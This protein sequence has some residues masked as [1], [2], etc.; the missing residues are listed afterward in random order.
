MGKE[1]DMTTN[2]AV[3]P[4]DYPTDDMLTRIADAQWGEKNN[5]VVFHDIHRHNACNHTLSGTI[6]EGE[7]EYGF[8]IHSGD[9]GGTVVEEWGLSE[10]VGS[11]RPEWI[12]PAT[13]VPSNSFLI[14]ENPTMFKVYGLWRKEE[15]FK[16]MVR[17]YNY[18]RHFQPGCKTEAHYREK[19]AKRGLKPGL[20]SNF[21]DAE[22][23]V[24]GE[25]RP[26]A[27]H[28]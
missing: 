8:I 16:E 12:E 28:D 23:A 15:W 4:I 20:L 10:D 18:D 1:S 21:T 22:L 14:D 26:E 5:G 9:W 11:Y 25:K 24:I 17:S 6:T 7:I 2:D 27:S 19:A 13:F 3:R